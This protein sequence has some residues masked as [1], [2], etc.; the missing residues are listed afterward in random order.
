MDNPETLETLDTQ[1]GGNQNKSK[2][3]TQKTLKNEQN[4]LC[5][6]PDLFSFLGCPIM[7]LEDEIHFLLQCPTIDQTQ[8]SKS[9]L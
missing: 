2:S 5:Q 6:K 7:E 1:N 9:T 8:L 4:G 3:T